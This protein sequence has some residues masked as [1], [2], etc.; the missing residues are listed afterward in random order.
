MKIHSLQIAFRWNWDVTKLG[1]RSRLCSFLKNTFK[2]LD[3]KTIHLLLWLFIYFLQRSNYTYHVTPILEI[4][5]WNCCQ[6]HSTPTVKYRPQEADML[7]IKNIDRYSL[8][9]T[10]KNV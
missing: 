4:S 10:K 2:S 3:E 8:V 1:S 7:V 5:D 6:Q 9:I